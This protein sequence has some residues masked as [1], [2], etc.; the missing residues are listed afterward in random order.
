MRS[1]SF[2]GAGAPPPP[3]LTSEDVSNSLKRGD[4]SRSQLCVGTPTNAVTLCRSMSSSA[5]SGSQRCSITS[6]SWTLKHESITGT[7]PVTWKSGH[8]EDE[9]GRVRAGGR[10]RRRRAAHD[11]L[12]RAVAREGHERLADRAVRGDGPLREARRPRRV[13]DRGVALGV[14]LD[15]RASALP[16]TTTS[17]QRTTPGGTGTRVS[18]RVTRIGTPRR[19]QA[20]CARAMR[21]GSQTRT[22]SPASPT[23]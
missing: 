21:S 9:A 13:Q 4:S 6:F 11:A 20:G 16:R 15:R 17:L 2:G 10:R 1:T 18:E 22:E 5:L 3:T 12:Q 7:Q 8:D 14:D 23:A 19:S